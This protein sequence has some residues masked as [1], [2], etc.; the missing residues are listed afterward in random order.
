MLAH[1]PG[2]RLQDSWNKKKGTLMKA[3]TEKEH[4]YYEVFL[5]EVAS[6]A[7]R[8]LGS[9][10]IRDDVGFMALHVAASSGREKVFQMLLDVGSGAS[11]RS[12]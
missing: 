10:H 8:E 5:R 6:V 7:K 11:Q 4:R 9:L 12:V 3:G 1:A 2:P